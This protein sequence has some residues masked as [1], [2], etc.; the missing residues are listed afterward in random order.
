[1]DVLLEKK[2]KTNLALDFLSQIIYAC[3]VMTQEKC[4]CLFCVDLWGEIL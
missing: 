2:K 4:S 3:P 1:V